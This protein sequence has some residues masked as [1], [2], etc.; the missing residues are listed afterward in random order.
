MVAAVLLLGH[1]LV[2]PAPSPAGTP[3][4]DLKVEPVEFPSGSGSLLRGWYLPGAAG[5]AGIVLM[6]GVRAN[7]RSMIGRARFLNAA[8]YSVLVFDFQAHGESPGRRITFGHLEA[9]DAQAA[10][11]FLRSRL[12]GEPIGV[13]GSSLGG[14][15]AVVGRQPLGVDALALEAV[16]PTLADAVSNRLAV[17]FGAIGRVLAPALL[18]QVEPRLGFDPESLEPIV[19][20]SRVRCP[21]LVIAGSA[22]TRTTLEESRRLFDAAPQPKELWVVAGAGHVDFHRFARV[23][24]ERRVL[25]FFERYLASGAG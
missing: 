9:F 15:A 14:A 2:A 20:V 24:Y 25:A 12:P 3:P 6:H 17:R 11:A 21:V 5:H 13:L 16:Y 23:E 1:L 10:V 19:G 18:L 4:A 8:A 22:D 7:R